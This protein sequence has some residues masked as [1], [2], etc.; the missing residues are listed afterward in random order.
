MSLTIQ[1]EAPPLRLD[2]TGAI[3]IGDSRVLLE[4]VMAEFQGGATPEAIAR[5]Y[6]T[7]TLAD[8][9]ATIAYALRHPREIE[10]YL[11]ERERMAEEVRAKIEAAQGDL[12]EIR[13][14]LLS[15]R[16]T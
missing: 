10:A 6:S 14:R 12:G 1:T 16:T 9:Y 15:R 13:R 5:N 7:I 4:V 11:A 2:E 8:A 3:R